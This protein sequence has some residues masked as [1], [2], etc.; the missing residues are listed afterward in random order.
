VQLRIVVIISVPFFRPGKNR[1]QPV[2]FA[3]RD[4]VEFVVVAPRALRRRARERVHRRRHDVVAIDIARH[5][6]VHRILADISQRT[7]IPRAG[8]Q[9]TEGHRRLRLARK[10]HVSR[11]L[12]LHKTRVGLVAVERL[13]H[14][15]PIRPRVRPRTV[16]VVPVRLRVMH[17]VQ[18][19]PRP[20][21]AILRP[22]Q[23]TIHQVAERFGTIIR[24]KIRGFPG[25][26]RKAD[27]VKVKSPQ[28]NA[29]LRRRGKSH[30]VALQFRQDEQVDRRLRARGVFRLRQSRPAQWPQRPMVRF[31]RFRSA[32]P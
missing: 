5:L 8:R 14:V 30:S 28:K 12:F 17:Q 11:D 20:A 3:D 29:L 2:I 16:L 26:G 24:Q 19:M 32:A 21:L 10:K 18:P 15:V 25:R 13:D 6:P 4:R 31:R 7:F 27:Q 23:E 22:L 9:E 1:L